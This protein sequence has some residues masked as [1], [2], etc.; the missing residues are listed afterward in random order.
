MWLNSQ[1]LWQYNGKKYLPAVHRGVSVLGNL[2]SGWNEIVIYVE[3][4]EPGELFFAIGNPVDWIWYN[5]LE[6]RYPIIDK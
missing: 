3:D 4:G 6:W 2:E 5:D 1:L